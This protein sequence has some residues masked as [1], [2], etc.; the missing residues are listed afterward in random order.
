MLNGYAE[1]ARLNFDT[2]KT[3]ATLAIASIGGIAAIS[4]VVEVSTLFAPLV[5]LSYICLFFS[6]VV[7]L[8][9]M[10]TINIGVFNNLTVIDPDELDRRAEEQNDTYRRRERFTKWG[11]LL[12]LGLFVLALLIPP[13]SLALGRA[14]AI[15]TVAVLVVVAAILYRRL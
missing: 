5:W 14:G 6:S 11:F 15:V 13:L 7:A 10:E 1:G 8:K 3:Y 9:T 4:S 2:F 12:G